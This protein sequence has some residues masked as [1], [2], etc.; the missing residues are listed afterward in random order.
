[1]DNEAENPF[2]TIE[3][4]QQYVH[5]LQ[6]ALDEAQSS[7]QQDIVAMDDAHTGQRRLDALRLVDYKLAQLRQHLSAGSRLLNDLRSLRRLLLAEREK[8][9][10]APTSGM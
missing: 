9:P 8:T 10:R 6:A 4:A 2:E 1:M 3:D 5:L 7:I